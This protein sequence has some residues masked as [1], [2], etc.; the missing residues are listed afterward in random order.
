LTTDR[1]AAFSSWHEC[2][3]R[4]WKNTNSAFPWARCCKS[5]TSR[6]FLRQQRPIP[7][8]AKLWHQGRSCPPGV[9]FVTWGWSYPLGVKFSVRPSILLAY[10]ERGATPHLKF[11]KEPA[12]EPVYQVPGF[13]TWFIVPSTFYLPTCRVRVF[14]P[15]D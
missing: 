1:I 4:R 3:G 12:S 14:A 10:L 7:F 2:R 13:G 9:N 15:G 11:F 6:V 5:E 8:R